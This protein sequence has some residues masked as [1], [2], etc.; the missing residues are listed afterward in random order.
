MTYPGGKGRCYRQ[1]IS[2]MP[3]HRAYIETNL[4]HG[5]V[6]RQ[7]KPAAENV[8]YD[9]DPDVIAW[10]QGR[11]PPGCEV[12]LG[13]GIAHLR[14]RAF[15]GDELVYCDPPYLSSTRRS[16]S[17]LYKHDWDESQHTA[18]LTVLRGLSCAAMITGYA[19]DLYADM[20]NGWRQIEVPSWGQAGR[21]TEVVWLNFAP[22]TVL[23]DYQHIGSTFR[24]REQ[25]RRRRART[26]ARIRALPP[27]ERRAMFEE[28]ASAAE[29]DFLAVAES[30]RARHVGVGGPPPECAP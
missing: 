5:A 23:H 21:V 1:L 20:L 10:W 30:L 15:R 7:K 19:S 2:L 29:S 6:L 18:A 17:R 8:G 26:L 11:T 16:K 27:M 13:D 28:L 22:A 14:T 3:P 24:E 4:G 9:L 25:I 12:R